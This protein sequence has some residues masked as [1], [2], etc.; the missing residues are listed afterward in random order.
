M[1]Q[2]IPLLTW[3]V[4]LLTAVVLA[5]WPGILMGLSQY[6]WGRALVGWAAIPLASVKLFRG[7]THATLELL[8]WQ[9]GSGY[10]LAVL[11]YSGCAYLAMHTTGEPFNGLLVVG[12]AAF[13]SALVTLP[14][15]MITLSIEQKTRYPVIEYLLSG[16]SVHGIMLIHLVISAL[17]GWLVALAAFALH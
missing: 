11:G 16:W 9:L 12:G 4:T 15:T 10:P 2:S 1:S 17:L 5:I 7:D 14:V 8:V 6:R 3:L 13:V